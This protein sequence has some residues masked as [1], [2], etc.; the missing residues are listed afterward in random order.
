MFLVLIRF[1]YYCSMKLYSC[2]AIFFIT[3]LLSNKIFN[4]KNVFGLFLSFFAFNPSNEGN[5][6]IKLFYQVTLS[7]S[8]NINTF[9]VIKQVLLNFDTILCNFQFFFYYFLLLWTRLNSKYYS[10]IKP[11]EKINLRHITNC[12]HTQPRFQIKKFFWA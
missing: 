2:S 8:F 11:K 9:F 10:S 5:K 6:E 7:C 12:I 4:V 1:L 3:F